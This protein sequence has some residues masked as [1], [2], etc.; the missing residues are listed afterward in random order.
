M[1]EFYSDVDC[2]IGELMSVAAHGVEALKAWRFDER[3]RAESRGV[4]I[5]RMA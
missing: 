4:F 2:L 5:F 3:D 1:S